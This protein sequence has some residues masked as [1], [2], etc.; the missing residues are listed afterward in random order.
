MTKEETP[1]TNRPSPE[2]SSSEEA[3]LERAMTMARRGMQKYRNALKE[4]AGLKGER[5]PADDKA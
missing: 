4:L 3:Q 5:P 1:Q 2:M